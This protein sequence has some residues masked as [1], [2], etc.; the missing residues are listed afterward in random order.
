MKFLS[1][2]G[3]R[4]PVR[5]M[6]VLKT[7]FQYDLKKEQEDLDISNLT[8]QYILTPSNPIN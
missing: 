8:D 4:L 3:K 5:N 7:Q 6:S 1:L 2:S